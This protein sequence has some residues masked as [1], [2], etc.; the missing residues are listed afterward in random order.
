M[1]SI[2]YC[3]RRQDT[4]Y[5]HIKVYESASTPGFAGWGV[6]DDRATETMDLAVICEKYPIPAGTRLCRAAFHVGH[7]DVAEPDKYIS[8]GIWRY[9]SADP[10]TIYR[11]TAFNITEEDVTA[12][13]DDT[14]YTVEFDVIAV[15]V[16]SGTV[17]TGTEY[18]ISF[19]GHG[20]G[21]AEDTGTAD[22]GAWVHTVPNANINDPTLHISSINTAL[23]PATNSAFS[24]EVW[25]AVASW[26][27]VEEGGTITE[28]NEDWH[29]ASACTTD[30]WV[31]CTNVFVDDGNDARATENDSIFIDLANGQIA[32]DHW[33][34]TNTEFPD[35]ETYGVRALQNIRVVGD[36]NAAD[37]ELTVLWTDIDSSAV[38]EVGWQNLVTL[39]PVGAIFPGEA[40]D[41]TTKI[42]EIA[43]WIKITKTGS[44]N[45]NVDYIE[46]TQFSYAVDDGK[47][48]VNHAQTDHYV[49]VD[50]Y[51]T[52]EKV[53]KTS[54]ANIAGAES[55]TSDEFTNRINKD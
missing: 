55:A 52:E 32:S 53:Y 39:A 50:N 48:Y 36:F 35:Y 45:D 26:D 44:T 20:V 21:I 30:G 37:S 31:D 1:G 54:V 40:F 33:L 22:D 4:A 49:W 25:G 16:G 14:K 6:R 51:P 28:V 47:F 12:F 38:P 13:T 18:Y 43:R 41:V 2:L 3:E 17:P 46:I 24:F 29:N 15:G 10:T 11:E 23:V 27:Q 5:Q 34:Y 9:N 19:F 8:V 42:P 7:V